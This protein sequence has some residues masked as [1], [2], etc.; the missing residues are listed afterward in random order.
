MW[1]SSPMQ[2]YLGVSAIGRKVPSEDFGPLGHR[3]ADLAFALELLGLHSAIVGG[4]EAADC[5]VH[6]SCGLQPID[7]IAQPRRV[8]GLPLDPVPTL[9]EEEPDGACV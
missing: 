8:C 6:G 5:H 4:C 1:R 9:V 7:L 2:A 3:Q